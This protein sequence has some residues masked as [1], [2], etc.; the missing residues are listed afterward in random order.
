MST[1]GGAR[2]AVSRPSLFVPD[3]WGTHW[4]AARSGYGRLVCWGA[5]IS[6]GF[7][8]SDLRQKSLFGKMVAD[9]AVLF[10]DAGS[11]F[12]SIANATGFAG[13][14]VGAT[15]IVPAGAW[16]FSVSGFNESAVF[17]T[18]AANGA[19][20]TFPLCRGDRLELWGLKSAGSGTMHYDIDGGAQVGD[21]VFT[22]AVSDVF[23][24]A[25]I[26]IASGVGP[27]TIVISATVGTSF[28]AGIRVYK[29]AQLGIEGFNMS[30]SGRQS[31]AGV[32]NALI[33]AGKTSGS[34]SITDS[35]PDVAIICDMGVNDVAAAVTTDVFAQNIGRLCKLAKNYGDGIA[36]LII[37]ASHFGGVSGTGADND[38][39]NRYPRYVE[40]MFAVAETYGAVFYNPWALGRNS[41][42]YW[43]SLNAWGI[44]NSATG[45]PGTDGI[46]PS[47][48]GAALYAA[49]LTALLS[50]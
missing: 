1:S 26:V 10:G 3:G 44:T 8:G 20:M 9:L 45:A 30:Q 16:T 40:Q 33:A 21:V 18:V 34:V 35:S 48:I 31:G 46:H 50:S 7:Y 38:A 27:H 41:W 5:S 25:P 47:D 24:S 15:Y 13:G 17:N 11:G 2:G 36:D 4:R 29:A 12:M 39:N 42:S 49:P 22:D 28:L 19:S 43:N 32:T 37:I 14:G 6:Q 23:K